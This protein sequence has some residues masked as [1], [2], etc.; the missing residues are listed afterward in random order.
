MRLKA[1]RRERGASPI[2]PKPCMG[3]S[4]DCTRALKASGAALEASGAAPE[5]SDMDLA[6]VARALEALLSDPTR[7][8]LRA[9]TG[10]YGRDRL[11]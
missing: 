11:Q 6:A 10:C 5:A 1:S 2:A 8:V 4:K 7:S 9:L 3:L